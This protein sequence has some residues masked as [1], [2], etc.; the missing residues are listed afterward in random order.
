MPDNSALM[1]MLRQMIR[2]IADVIDRDACTLGFCADALGKFLPE[3]AVADY[4]AGSAFREIA[5]R[6]FQCFATKSGNLFS[7]CIFAA[8]SIKS[9]MSTVK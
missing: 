2:V 4:L 9:R 3:S 1:H 5:R 8:A 6:D 7:S